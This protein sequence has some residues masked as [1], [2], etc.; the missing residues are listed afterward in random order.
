MTP[1]IDL[2]THSTVSD[3]T[4]SP[5]ELVAAAVRAGVDVVALTDHDTTI[6]W[7]EAAEAATREGIALVRGVEMSCARGG[8]SVHLLGYLVDPTNTALA[9]ELELTRDDRVPRLQAMVD[10]LA[11]DGFPVTWEAVLDEADDVTTLGRPHLAD[12]LV[13]AG[14]FPDRETA[15]QS[16]LNSRSPYYVGHHAA[17]P[18]AATRLVVAAGGV[19]V[20]AHPFAGMRRQ[21]VTDDLVA[22]MAR[23]GLSGVESDH[24]DHTPA[25]RARAVDLAH[26]LGLF[27]T[28]SS[29]YH[30]TGKPNELG[31]NTTSP[32]VLA[33]I[34]ERATGV[35]LLRP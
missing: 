29:D 15:F 34:E 31:E 26:R 17:D 23:A 27:T 18:V 24:R 10:K 33:A 8:V 7:S 11:A 25:Q 3:G 6:G 5:S 16:H 35:E 32:D 2:H 13:R 4:D 21:A 1:M 19:A 28:G 20:I 22:E 12:A 9:T 14:V 30:G